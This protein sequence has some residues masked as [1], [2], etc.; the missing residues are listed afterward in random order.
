MYY[1]VGYS[2]AVCL[3][4]HAF[5]INLEREQNK[6]GFFTLIFSN[7]TNTGDK[8]NMYNKQFMLKMF[9]YQLFPLT[10]NIWVN[11]KRWKVTIY[12]KCD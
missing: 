9:W 12:V 3:N 2:V 6:S 4:S 8:Q 11:S 5:S 7:K 10:E 1:Y